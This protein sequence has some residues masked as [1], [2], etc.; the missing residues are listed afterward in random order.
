MVDESSS[1][2][3]RESSNRGSFVSLA[4]SGITVG[5]RALS[6]KSTQN[7]PGKVSN[8]VDFLMPSNL[9]S[10]CNSGSS[11]LIYLINIQ[12]LRNQMEDG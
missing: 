9:F 11:L 8:S 2:L 12:P 4:E 3:Y 6:L 7:C 1:G 10:L 5:R